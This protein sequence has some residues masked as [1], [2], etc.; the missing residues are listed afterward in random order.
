MSLVRTTRIMPPH[1]FLLGGG[2]MALA[3]D[4]MMALYSLI[5]FF[6]IAG[7]KNG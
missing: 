4:F 7:I 5:H 2:W 1:S 6:A 3:Q